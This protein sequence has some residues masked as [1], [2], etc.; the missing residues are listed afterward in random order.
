MIFRL[1]RKKGGTMK[2]K[3]IK[4]PHYRG[5]DGGGKYHVLSD[6]QR[7]YDYKPFLV[8]RYTTITALIY[9]QHILLLRI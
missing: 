5:G 3:N 1:S 4:I 6:I 7:N 9:Q 2:E 8:Q